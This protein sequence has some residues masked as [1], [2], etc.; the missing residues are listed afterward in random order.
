MMGHYNGTRGDCPRRTRRVATGILALLFA[1]G[2][3]GAAVS[4]QER[5]QL[6]LEPQ[7]AVVDVAPVEVI[8]GGLPP[9]PAPRFVAPVASDDVSVAGSAPPVP[10][11]PAI[12]P[13]GLSQLGTQAMGDQLFFNAT[14][15]GG[16]VNSV[17]GTINVY[18]LGDELQ[19][20]L[21][22]DHRGSDGFNFTGPGSGYFES[23]NA[24]NGWMRLGGDERWV[25][26]EGGY[27][28]VREG[29]QQRVSSYAAERRRVD[30]VVTGTLQA[31]P[32][33][34]LSASL[35][36]SDARRVLST[37]DAN[38]ASPRESFIEVE[39]I[40]AAQ[41]SWPRLSVDVDLRYA[42]LSASG[43]ASGRVATRNIFGTTLAIEGVP[44]D[45]LTLGAVGGLQYRI[46]D[47][48]YTPVEGRIEY[49]GG[50]RLSLGLVG[51]LRTV[52]QAPASLW[53]AYPVALLADSI[54]YGARPTEETFVGGELGVGIVP[55]SVRGVIGGEWS[56]SVG[57]LM[58]GEFSSTA[59][60]YPVTLGSSQT[61]TSRLGLAVTPDAA[62]EIDLSWEASWLDR[63][64]GEPAQVVRFGLSG[65]FGPVLGR[66][67][68]TAP[69]ATT[70]VLPRVDLNAAW[71]L[72]RDVELRLFVNDALGPFDRSGRTRR[73]VTP[74]AGDPFVTAGFE[75]GAAV[76]VRF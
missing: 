56:S 43:T 10:L 16:S 58:I 50:E 14:L 70:V 65:N 69:L 42:F 12:P 60:G 18:R 17:L 19:F 38:A 64:T 29:L 1:F 48:L 51:G 52:E 4:A 32:R 23:A 6:Q 36:A 24:L 71:E 20:R 39:P 68:V 22:Y 25:E 62:F 5:E 34:Q 72:A 11:P 73:L 47:G 45:G 46:G 33:A 75:G 55:G 27:R 67:D 21:G 35:A 9:L 37:I 63:R 2:G 57:R 54:A 41:L 7:S 8:I 61:A 30:G 74:T 44:V 3:S 15:G 66:L 28:D 76:R 53:E 49:V 31:G 26:I 59:G 13:V 40:V